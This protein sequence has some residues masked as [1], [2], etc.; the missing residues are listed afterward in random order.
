M[1]DD[2][3]NHNLENP[4]DSLSGFWYVITNTYECLMDLWQPSGVE[5]RITLGYRVMTAID[6]NSMNNVLSSKFA[7]LQAA[8]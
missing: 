7:Q 1:V 8:I 6:E 3:D 2:D 4:K 5:Y